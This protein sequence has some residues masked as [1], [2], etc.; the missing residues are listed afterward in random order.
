MIRQVWAMSLSLLCWGGLAHATERSQPDQAV[1]RPDASIAATGDVATPVPIDD[2]Q[3]FVAVYNAVKQAYVDP[4]DDHTLMHNAIRGLLTGLDPHS[5]YFDNDDA[6][7]FEEQ[8]TGAYE[9]IGIELQQQQD[10]TLRVISSI[11]DTPA[12]RA[13]IVSGDVIIAIDGKPIATIGSMSPL[14]GRSGTWV[15]LRILRRNESP[16]NIRVQR[17]TIHVASVR[18]RMLETSVGYVRISTFQSNTAADFEARLKLLQSQAGDH[19]HGLVLDLRSNPGGLLT[20]AVKIADDLLDHGTIVTTRG[21]IAASDSHFD[22]TPGDLLKGAP[23]VII[24][25]AGSASASEV[26]A[27]ALH[28]NH[29]AFL[30]GSRTFGKG[31]VQTLLPLDNGDSIKLTTARYYTPSGRSIQAQGIEPDLVLTPE[32]TSKNQPR[33]VYSESNLP[34]HLSSDSK[35]STN[36]AVGDTLTGDGPI[37]AALAQLKRGSVSTQQPK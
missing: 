17:E 20:A 30:I 3:R 25:D 2:I 34:G 23:I 27:A 35:G 13:G 19:L 4:V 24:V 22:A 5:T 10:N 33:S 11:D 31:S 8:T 9:G 15:A 14:R 1:A 32:T 37:R 21:R 36:V 16:L 18:S 6:Q 29:R 26:L 28:D 12:A 7:S